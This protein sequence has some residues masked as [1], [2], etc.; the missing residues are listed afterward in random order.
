MNAGTSYQLEYPVEVTK[1]RDGVPARTITEV[2]LR[3]P[4]GRDMMLIDQFKDQPM[5]LTLEM[6]AQLSGL[7]LA[8]VG[9]FDAEDIGPLGEIA[10][11]GMA[12]GRVTGGTA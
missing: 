12:S 2:T 4:N 11:P 10:M 6:I 7:T 1:E 3:R 5:R 8:E 9:L